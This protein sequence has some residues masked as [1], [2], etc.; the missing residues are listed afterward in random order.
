M[1]TT[2]LVRSA[3]GTVTKTVILDKTKDQGTA[4]KID[5][6]LDAESAQTET[7][8]V[9]ARYKGK[10]TIEEAAEK[11]MAAMEKKVDDTL[12]GVWGKNY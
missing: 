2:E 9:T 6:M 8:T 7:R 4:A 12:R 11:T 10:K 3:S 5:Q 1:E